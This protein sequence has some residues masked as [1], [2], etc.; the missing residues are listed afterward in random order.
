MH[1]IINCCEAKFEYVKIETYG[2]ENAIDIH[3]LIDIKQA[4]SLNKETNF[5]IISNDYD[6]D[7]AIEDYCKKGIKV[8]RLGQVCEIYKTNVSKD[9]KNIE[10][11]EK[12][13]ANITAK[14]QFIRS[15]FGRY[16]KVSPYKENKEKIID[17]LL[18]ST[19]IQSLNNAL[20]KII[21]SSAIHEIR[22]QYKDII[23]LLPSGS[24]NKNVTDN[25]QN[26]VQ[27]ILI[28]A[29]FDKNISDYVIS[30]ICK[31]KG[32]KNQIYKSL[33]LKYEQNKD[34]NIYNYIKRYI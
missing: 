34:L 10:I 18:N 3:I 31:Y 11:N 6:F 8:K 24:N 26:S 4:Y 19:D 22:K 29:G 9:A 14:E 25:S 13:S 32:N 12:E 2:I 28:R 23:S 5:F 21:P 20:T 15:I 17:I 1:R 30:I 27:E 33:V 7:K 16:F